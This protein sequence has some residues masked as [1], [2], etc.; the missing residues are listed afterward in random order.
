MQILIRV[1]EEKNELVQAKGLGND[2]ARL[3]DIPLRADVNIYDVV[4]YD[5]QSGRK[6]EEG[7][8]YG[9][10]KV[11]QKSGYR[12]YLTWAVI[13]KPQ[14]FY[15]WCRT[16]GRKQIVIRLADWVTSGVRN[17][18]IALPPNLTALQSL[19]FFNR[20]IRQA[21]IVCPLL[22]AHADDLDRTK[23]DLERAIAWG[24]PDIELTFAIAEAFE[25]MG[26]WDESQPFWER[27]A[28]ATP[29]LAV[30][31]ERLAINY[32]HLAAYPQAAIEFDR[33]A[34]LTD[35]PHHRQRL[36]QARDMM[37]ART[38]L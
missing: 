3:L 14:A 6:E 20:H 22:A 34:D 12:A 19:I 27:L 32:A 33:A 7:M 25:E 21:E 24:G 9:L 1:D 5:A 15:E 30:T 37:W 11:V 8:S 23:S 29:T 18:I 4:S 36:Q 10:G 2:R 16:M 17:L 28:H 35:D 26:Q 31:R 38:R 13:H